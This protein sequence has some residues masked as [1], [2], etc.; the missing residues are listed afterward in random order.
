M[1]VVQVGGF[2]FVAGPN[3]KVM[4][5]ENAKTIKDVVPS[6][7]DAP[8]KVDISEEGRKALRE[9]VQN[10]P[11]HFDLEEEMRMREILPKL[12]LDPVY[13]HRTA[14]DSM[15]QSS[16][17]EIKQ[18]KDYYSIDDLVNVRM[19]AYARQYFRISKENDQGN[20][21]YYLSAGMDENNKLQFHQVSKEEDLEYLDE[22]FNQKGRSLGTLAGIQE[23]KWQIDHIFGG[24]P[25]LSV[26]LSSDYQTRLDDIMTKARDEVKDK[27]NKGE[28]ENESVMADDAKKIGIKYLR[29][30]TEFYKQ[31]QELFSNM[32]AMK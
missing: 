14:M 7:K 4:T 12:K 22:A 6:L 23:Q 29:Q 11:G 32:K 16:Y 2:S 20:R 24:K 3:T 28:Y 31:M 15:I 27:Y 18:H 10:M 8:I 26:K 5:P 30:D 25:A 17:D 13:E 21:E 19:D 1:N 9:Q